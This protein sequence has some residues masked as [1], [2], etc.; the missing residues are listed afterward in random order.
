MHDDRHRGRHAW[1][2][3]EDLRAAGIGNVAI[4]L[5]LPML[6]VAALQIPL[7]QLLV[8]LAKAVL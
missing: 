5:A 7:G 1:R 2:D 4:P 3:P 6:A 8:T